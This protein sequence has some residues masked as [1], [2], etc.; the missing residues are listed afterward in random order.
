MPTSEEGLNPSDVFYIVGYTTESI[1]GG[2]LI[3]LMGLSTLVLKSNE[4]LSKQLGPLVPAT[5]AGEAKRHIFEIYSVTPFL[6]GGVVPAAIKKIEKLGGPYMAVEFV[7]DVA[8][9]L[10]SEYQ[11]Q[12]P[13]VIGKTTRAELPP[14]PYLGITMRG[15]S[16]KRT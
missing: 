15:V 12:L 7:N 9:N 6:F 2:S 16:Y 13:A 11:I 8:Y 3:Q 14:P 10:C 1:G 5:R 4:T